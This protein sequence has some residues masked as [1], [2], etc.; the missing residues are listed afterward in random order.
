MKVKG[1]LG[2]E[3]D[4]S[5]STIT[6]DKALIIDNTGKITDSTTT[7]AELAHLSGVTSNV[8]TQITAAQSDATQAL[9]DAATAQTAINDH[10][11][12]TVAAHDASAI[13]NSPT[14]NLAASNVQDALNELQTDVD[15]RILSSEK[16]ANN[17]V[18]TLD[19]A[20]KVPVTQLPSAIMTYEGVWDASI[21]TPTLADSTGD[22]GMVYR[23][24]VAGTQNLGSGAITFAVGDYVILNSSLVWEKSDTTDA[25]ASV[26]SQVGVVVLDTDDIGE[27]ATNLYFTEARA[28]TASV[29]DTITDGIIDVA[30]SQNAVFDAL[31]TINSDIALKANKTLDNLGTTAINADLLPDTGAS[32]NLGSPALYWL[33]VVSAQFS[34]PNYGVVKN[35]VGPATGIEIKATGAS[36]DVNLTPGSSG[37]I[38]ASS[39]KISDVADPISAQDAA[40]KGY[41]D[42]TVGST[43]TFIGAENASSANVTGLVFTSSGKAIVEVAIDATAD[44]YEAFDVLV[45]KKGA[46]YELSALSV[47]D[48]SNVDFSINASGQV[49]YTSS[50]YA[51]LVVNGLTIK[52]KKNQ[53]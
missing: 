12:D 7:S 26:N 19:G 1:S 15:S 25:V 41:V 17:G 21:N 31:A 44:L 16:G 32:K 33:D 9:A 27:G 50:S 13:A 34:I 38:R 6:G 48:D 22:V 3:G 18:A 24:A 14:G 23:V 47:G 49:Q 10:M 2:V 35:A 53:L 28:K 43:T 5:V 4:L 37:V 52:F 36:D 39:K 40:T 8:Q 11:S 51:G 46:S 30:P 29:A 45:V 42:S 20:G